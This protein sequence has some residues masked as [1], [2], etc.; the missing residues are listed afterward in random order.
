ML[1]KAGP[2]AAMIKDRREILTGIG[3][4]ALMAPIAGPA[5]GRE[6]ATV[7]L[8]FDNRRRELVAYPQT[9]P[10]IRLTTRPP[11]LETPL[12][13]LGEAITP[14]DAFFVRYHLSDAPPAALDAV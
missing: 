8:G 12:P 2:E 3:S 9:R 4:L 13:L 10:L 6:A 1:G 14:N 5:F 7:D 11:Q